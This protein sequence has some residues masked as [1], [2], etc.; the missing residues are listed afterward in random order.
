MCQ[1]PV[2]RDF[3]APG[4]WVYAEGMREGVLSGRS[5]SPLERE[6]ICRFTCRRLSA[7]LRLSG[8]A[9]ARM[10]TCRH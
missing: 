4:V 9:Y 1:R 2:A 3:H 7:W 10:F 6:P 5:S 8:R